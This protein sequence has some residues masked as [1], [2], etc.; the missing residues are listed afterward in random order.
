MEVSCSAGL[1][2]INNFMHPH[3]VIIDNHLKEDSFFIKGYRERA[4]SL[5]ISL[6]E[7]PKNAE[8]TLR[9]ISRLDS[10]ALGG[11]FSRRIGLSN[12][13]NNHLQFGIRSAW[14]LSFM[15][16]LRHLGHC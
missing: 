13:A 10:T 4:S 8:D 5:D 12:I 16:S 1:G 11:T 6:I 14:I 7:L 3:A 2:H 9:W 15:R